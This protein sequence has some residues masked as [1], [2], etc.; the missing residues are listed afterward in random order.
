MTVKLSDLTNELDAAPGDGVF[1]V[2][3]QTVELRLQ[4][5]YDAGRLTGSDFATVYLGALQEVL[6]SSIAFLLE[7][8]G[9]ALE[10]AILQATV[11]KQWGYNVDVD[12]DGELTLGNT[13]AAGMIDEQILEASEKVRLATGQISKIYADVAL[14]G[15]QQVTELAQTTTPTGGILGAKKSLIDAQTL[16]FA[17]DTK[18]KVLKQMLEGYAVTLSIAGSATVPD[19]TKEP[20]IDALTDEILADVGSAVNIP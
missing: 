10:Q 15:Q 5:Q 20:Q 8:D 3:I 2:L 18:Q 19:A 6:K 16:G 17:S 13:T 12:V 7:K 1:D 9:K 14:T 4:D 11:E